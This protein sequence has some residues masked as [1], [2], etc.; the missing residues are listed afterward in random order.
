M[1]ELSRNFYAALNHAFLLCKKSIT[2]VSCSRPAGNQKY[3]IYFKTL[4]SDFKNRKLVFYTF[5]G[6]EK[7]Y[8]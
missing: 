6:S 3:P 5:T 4:L 8:A 1:I 7:G 2:I